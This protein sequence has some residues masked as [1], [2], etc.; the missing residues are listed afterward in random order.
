MHTWQ[1][2]IQTMHTWQ[3]QIQTMYTWLYQIQKMHTWQYQ[4][5]TMHTWQYQIH[6]MHTWQYQIHTMHTWQ[7]QIHTM[8]TW[9]YQIF[10]VAVL[11]EPL[12]SAFVRSAAIAGEDRS[13]MTMPT[14]MAL[15]CEGHKATA[16]WTSNQYC[17]LKSGLNIW[18]VDKQGTPKVSEGF[19]LRLVIFVRQVIASWIWPAIIRPN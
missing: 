17:T 6:T 15:I 11:S 2:Q 3:Y 18:R 12:L 4:I 14:V 19:S 1:Y 7:Y 10:K 5:H 16:D 9:Q 13:P 8:H